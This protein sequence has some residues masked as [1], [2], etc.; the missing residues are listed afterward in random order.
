[1]Q[2]GV[3][4]AATTTGGNTEATNANFTMPRVSSS[5]EGGTLGG[6]GLGLL[7]GIRLNGLGSAR[8]LLR[9]GLPE[10]EQ[11]EQQLTKNPSMTRDIPNMPLV[12]NFMNNS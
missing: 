9:V 5:G 6:S 3:A 8:G 2:V 4:A 7:P 1:M 10:L 11:M 12:Q